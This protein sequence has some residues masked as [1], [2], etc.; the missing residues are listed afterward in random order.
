MSGQ[1]DS[2]S[3]STG[4]G[5]ICAAANAI[6][7]SPPELSPQQEPGCACLAVK[8]DVSEGEKK[9]KNCQT[10]TSMTDRQVSSLQQQWDVGCHRLPS[11][12]S[13]ADSRAATN[14]RAAAVPAETNCSWKPA[15]RIAMSLHFLSTEKRDKGH[16]GIEICAAASIGPDRGAEVRGSPAFCTT[17]ENKK[18]CIFGRWC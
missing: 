7:Q 18:R 11:A 17:S 10:G 15:S 1:L 5:P 9:I 13:L 2:P 4:F 3:F 6:L 16:G 12:S 8:A 14:R